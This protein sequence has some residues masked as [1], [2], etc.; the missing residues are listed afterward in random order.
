M[1]QGGGLDADM[2][3]KTTRDPI[4]NEADNG[5]K[6]LEGTI[7][8]ARTLEPNSAS[9][10][11]FINTTDNSFLD[12]RDKTDDGWGYCVFG[13]V[14]DGMNVVKKIEQS[15]TAH[16]MGYEDVPEETIV[17]ESATILDE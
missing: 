6:N 14:I 11:F 1:I 17:I 5:L 13:K 7:A 8:M 3:P 4:Q 10:Q 16:R 12:H 9:A 2:S 15:A